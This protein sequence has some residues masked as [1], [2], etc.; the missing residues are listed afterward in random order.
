V[1]FAYANENP[2]LKAAYSFYGTA[3]DS[4]DKVKNI[5]C[6]VYGFYAENDARVDATIPKAEE[7]MKTAGKKYEPVI[8]KGAGHGFMRTGEPTN[9]AVREA[10][11]K[12]RDEA[13]ARWKTLLKQLP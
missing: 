11:K 9:P 6:P 5:P 13:W 3:A 10:D 4:A 7:L 1:T 2:K 12:A 8:Y